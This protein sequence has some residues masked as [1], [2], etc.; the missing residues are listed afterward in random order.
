MLARSPWKLILLGMTSIA[1]TVTAGNYCWPHLQ[2]FLQASF[3]GKTLWD[4]LSLLVIPVTAGLLSGV[5]VAV[6]AWF[7]GQR[8]REREKSEREEREAREKLEREER[9]NREREQREEREER[10]RVERCERDKRLKA[11]SDERAA[12][13]RSERAE[14]E[15]RQKAEREERDLREREHREERD[16][17]RAEE[18][19]DEALQRYFDRISTILIDKQ[20]LS[21]AN[22]AKK[23]GKNYKDPA[24]ESARVVISARTKLILQSFSNHADKKTAVMRFLID[25]GIISGLRVSLDNAELGDVQLHGGALSGVNLRG[26]NLRGADLSRTNFRGANLSEADLSGANLRGANLTE[27]DLSSSKLSG[28]GLQLAN[29]RGA[30]LSAAR[31]HGADLLLSNLSE[32]DLS[33]ADLCWADLNRIHWDHQ[34]TWPEASQFE[35]AKNIPPALKE[36]LGIR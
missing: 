8:A 22:A 2:S 14:R 6:F 7:S 27:V 5:P 20:V 33:E 32:T 11:A 4:Y 21:L 23:V 28:A 24:V 30:D 25:S 13:E 19:R 15:S 29:L 35:D 10:D 18:G 3:P 9:E 12:K 36:Q 16:R 31:L 34:T 26:S 1:L 17:T